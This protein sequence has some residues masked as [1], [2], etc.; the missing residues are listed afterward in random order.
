MYK[1]ISL[2]LISV[3]IFSCSEP[4]EEIESDSFLNIAGAR[5]GLAS[6]QPI[7][8]DFQA[9][10][11]YM[12]L[13][14]KLSASRVPLFGDLHVHTTYSFDA[15]IFGTLAT[16]DDAY[17]FA[18]GGSIRHPAGFEMQLDVPMDF[19]GVSDHAYYLGIIR[20]MALGDSALSDHPVAEG[21]DSLDEDVNFRRSVFLRFANFASTGNGIEVMDEQ[22]V[23]SAWDDIIAS[24]N[25]HYEPGK[26]TTF[27]AYEYTG[28][29]PD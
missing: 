11:P 20:E 14:P 7:D 1:N 13:D 3:F 26:F 18:K 24:A 10:D 27:I 8:W 6:Q 4:V 17:E 15:Y 25:R 2:I 19:Y 23:K 21:I 9:V 16:P 22:V 5:V 12:N 29:G 28:T